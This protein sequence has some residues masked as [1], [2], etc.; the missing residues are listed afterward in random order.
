MIATEFEHIDDRPLD[1]D[2]T[3]QGAETVSEPRTQP[4]NITALILANIALIVTVIFGAGI[5][6]NR[7]GN[8]ETRVTALEAHE[9]QFTALVAMQE[10]L[11][12][13]KDELGR[14]R[15]RLDSGT[16]RKSRE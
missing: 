7:V 4:N 6:Y 2:Q 10:Q 16:A 11:K 9:A 1:G 12:T 3:T 5:T 13:I 14:V 15:D 8:M